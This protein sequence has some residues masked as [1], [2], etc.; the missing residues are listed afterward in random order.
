M[1]ERCSFLPFLSK[2]L[3]VTTQI[4]ISL[5][6]FIAFK[7]FRYLIS[8]SRYNLCFFTCTLWEI[9]SLKMEYITS[10]LWRL[11]ILFFK[12]FI[13]LFSER[14]EGRKRGRETSM[15]GCLSH[16]PYWGPGLKPRH[17]PWLGNQ[18]SDP[19]VCRPALNPLS[20]TSQGCFCLFVF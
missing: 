19:L 12:D 3:N 18:A 20:N 17:V 11:W 10:T 4:E 6:I 2:V 7:V 1:T 15:C 13:Y 8:S 16:A 9:P 14:G 5:G